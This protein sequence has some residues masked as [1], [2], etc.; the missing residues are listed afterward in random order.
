MFACVCVRHL[1]V[2]SENL[3]RVSLFP[4]VLHLL[5]DMAQRLLILFAMLVA[6]MC[7]AALLPVARGRLASRARERTAVARDAD[8]LSLA[9]QCGRRQQKWQHVEGEN[10]LS[11]GQCCRRR[12]C[13][14]TDIWRFCLS[15]LLSPRLASSPRIFKLCIVLEDQ[16]ENI[17]Y[18][19]GFLKPFVK[20][21]QT[22]VGRMTIGLAKKKRTGKYHQ[23]CDG[24]I[25][26]N[27][28]DRNKKSAKK[29]KQIF[30]SS[31]PPPTR[32]A[33]RPCSAA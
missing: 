4:P 16:V 21:R 28:K 9:K 26:K 25:W 6:L 30:K 8:P 12:C 10:A 5:F 13:R 23:E 18:Y 3:F 31:R 7:A 33:R 24:K 27:R 22:R 29:T 15:A 11:P 19:F 14:L 1:R 32:G 17:N 2:F 20:I